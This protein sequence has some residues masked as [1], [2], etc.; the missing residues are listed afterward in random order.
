MARGC[1]L[2]GLMQRLF[3]ADHLAIKAP[4]LMV[5][6]PDDTCAEWDAVVLMSKV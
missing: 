2:P 1:K 3:W 5:G 4:V 6:H